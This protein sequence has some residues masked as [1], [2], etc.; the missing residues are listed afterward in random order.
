[1]KALLFKT[2]N[3]ASFPNEL[4]MLVLRITAGLLMAI[5]HGFGKFPVNPAFVQGVASLGFPMPE[6][7]AY[8]AAIAE[9][10]GGIFLALGLF[11]RPA[12]LLLAVTMGVAA[13]GQ[14]IAD[15]LQVKELSIIYLVI[16]LVFFF[17]GANRFSV[18]SLI[19]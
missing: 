6:F 13:F 18:D 12:A 8:A 16:S 9:L 10:A 2:T 5:L 15:P 4:S 17:R 14:H 3:E 7:F 11:T 1:M 19:K